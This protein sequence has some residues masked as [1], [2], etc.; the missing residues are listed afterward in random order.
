MG[1]K[2]W[3]KFVVRD[4]SVKQESEATD[5]LILG[6]M[7]SRETRKNLPDTSV[8]KGIHFFARKAHELWKWI[9]DA[10]ADKWR[11]I[12]FYP[13]AQFVLTRSITPQE[14]FLYSVP[15]PN[16]YHSFESEVPI[17]VIKKI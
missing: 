15:L 8:Y 14:R 9:E 13:I 6:A 12:I 3:A 2:Q 16:N 17:E 4:P 11:K 10:P 1:N 7:C 5:L